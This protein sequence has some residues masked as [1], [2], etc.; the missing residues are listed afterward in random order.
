MIYTGVVEERINDKYKSGRCRVRIFGLHSENRS[1]LPTSDLPWA[2]PLQSITSAAVSGVGQSPTGLVEGSWVLVSFLDDFKQQPIILGSIGAVP[3]GVKAGSTGMD[4][5]PVLNNEENDAPAGD[6]ISSPMNIQHPN[7]LKLSVA[8]EAFMKGEEAISSLTPGRND[9]RKNA[10]GISDATLIYSYKDSKDVW[11]IGW[12]STYLADGS[13]VTSSTILTKKQCDDLFA[14]TTENSYSKGVRKNLNI[15]VTQGMFD[16]LVSM[17]YNMGVSGLVRSEMFSALN[18]GRYADASALIPFT[19]AKGLA[20]RRNAERRLFDSQGWPAPTTN[21]LESTPEQVIEKSKT[22]QLIRTTTAVTSNGDGFKDPAGIYPLYSDEPDTNRLA[23]FENLSKTIVA[24]K[25]ASRIKNVKTSTGK[26]WSQ[27]AVPYNAKYPYNHVKQSESGHIEEFDDTGDN[28]RYHRYHR[29]GTYQEVDVNGTTVN[30]IVGDSY[31]ITDRDGFIFIKGS[32]NVTIQGD[33]NIR[34]ENDANL[35]VLGNMKTSVSGNYELS[36]AGNILVKSA[37]EMKTEAAQ[38]FSADATEVHLNSGYKTDLKTP[39][40]KAEGVAKLAP[41]IVPLRR[42]LFDANYESPEEG[43]NTEFVKANAKEFD[44]EDMKPVETKNEQE[45]VPEHKAPAVPSGSCE[46]LTDKDIK[47]AYRL[48]TLFTLGDVLTG[49]SGYPSGLNYG[50]T[51]SEIVCNLKLLAINCL[52]PIKS[53]FPN[54]II[55]NTWRSEK[56]NTK[57]GGSKTSDHLT[58]CA[59]DI[60]FSGFD[61]AKYYEAVVEI[62]KMLPAYRQLILEYKGSSTWIHISYKVTDNKCQNL[63]MDAS[64]NKVIQPAGKFILKA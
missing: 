52:D 1:E 23:R 34:V 21:A 57:V 55:T 60:Q 10:S 25:D 46:L 42:A 32:C 22:A 43:D 33:S 45:A 53:R 7:E 28:E 18:S 30:R 62:Q 59:A 31:E 50:M 20:N 13:R 26:T 58:G 44:E 9:F 8:G 63:T 41:L 2:I 12:G 29:S 16:A 14:T 56:V 27:P 15:P 64:I 6:V 17:A 4:D 24:K 61:R 37:N 48:S 5:P 35:Q 49:S 47:P 19:R 54:M 36:V 38:L 40:E 11:T 51:S 39:T 3:S